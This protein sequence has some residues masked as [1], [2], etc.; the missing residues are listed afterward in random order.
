[1]AGTDYTPNVADTA[2]PTGEKVAR[3][4]AEELRLI[5][6]LLA[7][8][9]IANAS[10]ATPRQSIQSAKIDSSGLNTALT[11][12]AGLRPGL[13][14]T[15]GAAPYQ[16]SYASG[17]SSGKPI[18]FAESVNADVVDILGSNLPVSNTSFLYKDYGLTYG[19]TLAPPQY[20]YFY[21][22]TAQ[23]THQF[24]GAAG[25]TTFLDDYGNTWAAQGNARVQTNQFKFGTGGLGAAGANNILTGT[26]SI[27]STNITS[28]GPNGW[29]LR[30]WVYCTTL[31]TAGND[32]VIM[33]WTN[34]GSF[35]A[36]LRIRNAAG[37]IKFTYYLSS[38]G[39][40][41]DIAS[42]VQGTTTPVV[43]TWY[44]IELT[45]DS[46]A[47]I[48][49]L[50]VNGAQENSTASAS[51]VCTITGT[52]IGANISNASGLQG[53]I[54]KPQFLPYCDHPNGTAYAVPTAAPS[55]IATGISSDFFSI[56]DMKMYQVTAASTAAG[57]N[58]TLTAITRLYLG[59][60]DTSGAAVTAVRNY[61]I[62]GMYDSGWTNTLPA[63]ATT[64][65]RNHNLGVSPEI[66]DLFVENITTANGYAVGRRFSW[67]SSASSDGT[68]LMPG[69]F[70]VFRNSMLYVT[71]NNTG[72]TPLNASTFVAGGLVT[73]NWKYKMIAQ[74]G[75]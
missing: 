44:Y 15:A 17:F 45:Y 42:A 2:Q 14:T 16:L 43:N 19:S 22:R 59:E 35:G 4:G 20:G 11:T 63:A 65:T 10:G 27:R 58:P 1:M 29:A 3:K 69:S 28:M 39:T 62:R 31:P 50:Y 32:E 74:R 24:A 36:L 5:K 46:L 75:W 37:T 55:V 64:T 13:S 41:Y 30:C 68:F 51:R 60:A 21:D 61:G 8:L 47:G 52:A 72:W 49:R 34:A 38:N 56:P 57:T 71:P 70:T 6:A 12:G 18:D 26:D 67:R 25:A 73:A 53:Y 40:G 54:D 33:D 66:F 48:Y 23:S 7:T 9:I